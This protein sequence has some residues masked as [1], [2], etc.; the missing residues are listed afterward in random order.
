MISIKCR[1]RGFLILIQQDVG[2]LYVT[3]Y[4]FLSTITKDYEGSLAH[5]Q[6]HC[7]SW[8]ICS[9]WDLCIQKYVL[10]KCHVRVWCVKIDIGVV[11]G[12]AYRHNPLLSQQK[13]VHGDINSS[14][15]ML[16]K[17]YD[18]MISSFCILNSISKTFSSCGLVFVIC[19]ELL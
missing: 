13:V 9:T 18:T 16:D 5:T 14:N 19:F 7:I 8:D 6:H 17:N 4:D 10:C 1:N 3:M 12:L 2:A 15:I 11:R